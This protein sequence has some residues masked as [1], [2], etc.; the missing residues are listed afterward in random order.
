MSS[1]LFMGYMPE[2]LEKILNNLNDEFYSLYSCALV[3]RHWCKM[4]IPILWQDPFPSEKRYRLIS[5]YFSSLSEDQKLALK[6]QGINVEFPKPLF[7]YAIFLKVLDLS[8][9]GFT[10]SEYLERLN[11]TLSDRGLSINFISNLLFK[12]FIESGATLHKLD[13]F[14]SYFTEIKPEI[15]NSLEQNP[16]FFSRI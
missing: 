15:F 13:L 8:W 9:I 3:S 16:Q 6:G 14:Y 7:D 4:S 11:P 5:I 2:L 12:F 1:K 10:V